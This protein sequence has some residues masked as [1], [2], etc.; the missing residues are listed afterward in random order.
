KGWSY[1]VNGRIALTHNAAPYLISAPVQ[2]NRTGDS[3]LALNQQIKS[4]LTSKGVNDEELTRT[5]ANL[6][7]AL[8]GQFESS[9]AV[10]SAMQQNALF[11]RP[12]NYYETLAG[13]Y[14]ALDKSAMD[15]ALRAAL[16]PNGFVWVVVGD[17]KTVKPQL[18]KLGIPVEVATVR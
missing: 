4:M 1:G 10:L 14:R 16:D 18:D 3:I 17:A 15:R 7:Q 5:I 6:S 2:A 8:P 11:G 12:D 13:R 9:E